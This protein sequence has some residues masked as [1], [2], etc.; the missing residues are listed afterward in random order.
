MK[1]KKI[2][3]I[4]LPLTSFNYGGIL[5]AVAL[6]EYLKARNNE[7][8]YIDRRPRKNWR[9]FLTHFFNIS[10]FPEY[11][12]VR[13]KFY[14]EIESFFR[15]NL[16]CTPIFRSTEKVEQYLLSNNFD[17]IITG[18]DQVWR[19]EYAGELSKDLFLNYPKLSGVSKVSYA[20]S[21]GKDRW[22]GK[23]LTQEVK[24]SLQNFSAVSVREESGIHI[25][26]NIFG[27]PAVQHIDPTMLL[28]K[29]NYLAIS[30]SSLDLHDSITSYVLDESP[31]NQAIIQ[32]ISNALNLPVLK[33]GTKPTI[34]RHNYKLYTNRQ[35]DS[36]NEW[37]QSFASARFVVTD[38][39]HGVVFSILFNKP[40]IAIG[41]K[42]RGLTRFTSMLKLFNLTDRL[43]T[44]E[45]QNIEEL[46]FKSIDFDETN[47]I[48][49]KER[50]R[51]NQ[52]F[53]GIC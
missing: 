19:A 26:R 21:F 11:P 18:S 2:G 1:N 48:L 6:S 25:C 9:N 8:Y 16:N 38:S 31:K 45:K 13:K 15:Q 12:R 50:E 53:A 47:A 23:N 33:I 36:I 27:I 30:Q 34:K 40:F 3:I 7:V 14:E 43:I 44:D 42:R 49:K 17:V 46:V 39:F 41:N 22:D 35:A 32:S 51:T 10:L 28:D 24:T 37:I 20:A 4:T 5:Q 29:R 52:Y